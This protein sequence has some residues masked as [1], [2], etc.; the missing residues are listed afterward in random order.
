M[1]S[2]EG[3]DATATRSTSHGR[4]LNISL[5][6][7]RRSATTTITT[8]TTTIIIIITIVIN[9]ITTIIICVLALGDDEHRG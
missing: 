5:E 1:A 8:I 7:G 3:T 6:R 4:R 9:T 2:R